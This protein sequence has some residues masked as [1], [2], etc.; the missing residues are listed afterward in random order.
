MKIAKYIIGAFALA[1]MFSCEK[2]ELLFEGNHDVASTDALFHICYFESLTKK[3]ANYIDS[4]YV[5]GK[6]LDGVDGSGRLTIEGILP[7]D[8]TRYYTAPSGTVNIRLYRGGDAVYDKDVVLSAGKQDIYVTDLTLDP[9]VVTMTDTPN[10][11]VDPTVENFDTD[12][13]A[14]VR[15]I[16]LL[17]E[18]NSQGNLAPTTRTL[19]YQWRDRNDKKDAETGDYHWTNIG[20]PVVFG[21]YT[22]Y[23]RVIVHK[24]VYNSSGY[25]TVYYRAI[26]AE[27][28][29][30][31]LNDYWTNYIG[32]AYDH[33]IWGVYP[34]AITGHVKVEYQQ[35]AM[36]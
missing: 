31:I 32:R 27:D 4:I 26:D 18:V 19:Q 34:S 10:T 20:E 9:A 28:N 15:F 35:F 16:N 13:I 14:A 17:Y 25:C 5:N 30:V 33:I 11:G 12:S 21:S 7:S 29:T 36:Y 2:H 24:S 6:Y 8:G 23:D 1:T 3:T 22:N